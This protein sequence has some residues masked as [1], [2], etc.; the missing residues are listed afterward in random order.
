MCAGVVWSG[1]SPVS[2]S[3]PSLRASTPIACHRHIPCTGLYHPIGAPPA[4]LCVARSSPADCPPVLLSAKATC[5]LSSPLHLT[6]A[7]ARTWRRHCSLHGSYLAELR[8][9]G[10]SRRKH[11]EMPNLV[12]PNN[13]PHAR[14]EPHGTPHTP[15]FKPNAALTA[16]ETQ[17][18]FTGCTVV[19]CGPHLSHSRVHCVEGFANGVTSTCRWR[20]VCAASWLAS[21]KPSH[22]TL[23]S[24]FPPKVTK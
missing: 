5:A 17:R 3:H 9:P 19:E 22:V 18:L 4:G 12:S 8:P 10:E 15:G 6:V 2:M 24:M 1:T 20:E 11:A 23:L 7:S 14:E 13:T 21:P 16:P